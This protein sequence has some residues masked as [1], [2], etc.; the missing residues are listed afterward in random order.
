MILDAY[1]LLA[2][3]QAITVSAA[4]TDYI[5]TLAKGDANVGDWFVVR[6]DAAATAGGAAEVTF[7]LE[8]DSDSGFATDLKNLITS[9]AIAVADLT[10]DT[11]VF[12]ARIPAG[13][14]RYLRGY[15]TVATGPL[16]AGT[17]DMFIVSDQD[18]NNLTA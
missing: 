11:I 12:A 13:A 9:G 3:E 6:A 5:D 2:D 17:F 4:S 10:V 16:T 8:T 15:A 7:A 14:L 1:T 18:F